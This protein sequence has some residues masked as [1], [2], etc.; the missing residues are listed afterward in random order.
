M[1]I[2]PGPG[3]VSPIGHS[4]QAH[5]DLALSNFGI[6]EGGAN[7][8]DAMK[9]VFPGGNIKKNGY[10]YVSD[11][12]GLGIDINETAAKK[13]PISNNAGNWTVRRRDGSIVTP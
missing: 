10:I 11:A 2:Q 6:Q 13:Y 7:M 1:L 5:M 3:D 4:A 8:P 9:E 12:P